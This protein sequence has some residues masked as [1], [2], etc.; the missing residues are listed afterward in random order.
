[1]ESHDLHIDLR[2]ITAAVSLLAGIVEGSEDAIIAKDRTG[3]IISWNPAAERLFG[4]TEE[5]AIGRHVSMLV[6]EHRRGEDTDAFDRILAGKRVEHYETE[7]MT[8]SGDVIEVAV[9]VSALRGADGTIL[10]ASKIVRDVT[11]LRRARAAQEQLAAIIGDSDDAIISKDREGRITSWNRAAERIFGYT[12]AEAVGQHVSLIFPED[13]I[14]RERDILGEILSG[15][16]VDHYETRRRTRDG[17]VIEV[18]LTV[19][20]LRG[21]D[22]EIIGASKILRDVTDQKRAQARERH[23]VELARANERLAEADRAKDE[24]LAI[25]NHELRTPLTA[26]AGFTDTLL[27]RD[28]SEDQRREFLEII[29]RQA[30][31]LTRLVDDLLSLTR[32][33]VDD[34][35]ANAM[36]VPVRAVVERILHEQDRDDIEVAGDDELFACVDP[37]HLRQIVLNYVDNATKYGAG[38]IGVEVC[39][40]GANAIVSVTDDGAG[41]PE[42]VVPRLFDAFTRSQEARDAQ[43]PGTGLGLSIVRTLARAHE[44]EAWYERGSSGGSS[45]RVSLPLA[46]VDQD[47]A[48]QPEHARAASSG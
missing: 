37:E 26:I 2:R 43:V 23:A 9:T 24:F 44:G 12:A 25:A 21:A 13:L 6:P 10:G 33:H 28:V 22:G 16:K 32:H 7:R 27:H 42:E 38:R 40:S 17:R 14:G 30:A 47:A 35:S 11:D 15:L 3:A 29:D 46:S 5:E 39:R 18:A 31:R 48:P 8:Q 20:P 1:M 41:V 34:A 36:S 45:F 19:S 4:Y